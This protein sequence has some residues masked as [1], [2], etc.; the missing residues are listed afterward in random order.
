[1]EDVQT[2]KKA[3]CPLSGMYGEWGLKRNKISYINQIQN[4][5]NAFSL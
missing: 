5:D 3:I 4:K 1:M 2:N